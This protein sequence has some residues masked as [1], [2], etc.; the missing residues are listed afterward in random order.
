MDRRI[1]ML[2]GLLLVM[3]CLIALQAV[4]S[5]N[6]CNVLVSAT[7]VPLITR[8]RPTPFAV[9]GFC[10][11]V[12]AREEKAGF[13]FG[14]AM[15]W[16][17]PRNDPHQVIPLHTSLRGLVKQ[18]FKNWT[19]FLVLNAEVPENEISTIFRRIEEA[20]ISRDRLVIRA[21]PKDIREGEGFQTE[22]RHGT[23]EQ[24]HGENWRHI[25]NWDS[26]AYPGTSARNLAFELAA[27]D[28]RVTHIAFLDFD[29][30]FVANHLEEHFQNYRRFPEVGFAYSLCVQVAQ[31]WPKPKPVF[32]G[33][34]ATAN[35]PSDYHKEIKVNKYPPVP[36]HVCPSTMTWDIS[37]VN[38]RLR[39]PRQIQADPVLIVPTC[40]KMYAPEMLIA[41]SDLLQR[42]RSLHRD[43]KGE[44]KS[45]PKRKWTLES[46]HIPKYTVQYSTPERRQEIISRARQRKIN[47][48]ES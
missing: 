11:P 16:Y 3:T 5:G 36:C 39:F 31:G 4:W 45:F 30:Q 21:L 27:N 42:L 37:K 6:D 43:T 28:K 47:T 1:I 10:P 44:P 17:V 12:E 15:N 33:P 18:T 29:D 13:H 9:S 20:G 19:L 40:E 32:W 41:D 35:A 8:Q 7:P 2:P 24:V 22:V 26:I 38:L 25:A 14:V 23:V 46:V 34:W 48:A